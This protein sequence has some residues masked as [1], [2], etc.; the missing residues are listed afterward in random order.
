M[1]RVYRFEDAPKEMQ[2]L[3]DHGGDE[4]HVIIGTGHGFLPEIM[5][6]RDMFDRVVQALDVWD[7]GTGT[8][9]QSTFMG[10]PCIVYITAHA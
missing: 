3:S 1:I 10:E 2:A 4:E 5:K 9:H 6:Q 7:G 8:E